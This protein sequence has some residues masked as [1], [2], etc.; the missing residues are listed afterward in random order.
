MQGTWL[1]VNKHGRIAVLTNYREKTSAQAVGLRSR[2]SIINSFLQLQPEDNVT[3]QQYIEELVA[4][5]DGHLA[6][7][8]SLACGDVKGPLAIVSNRVSAPDGITWIAEEKGQTVGLSNT[9][10]GDPSWKKINQ[11][12]EL[13]KSALHASSKLDESEDE[14]IARLL[15]LLSIDTL[16]RLHEG[17]DLETYINLLSESIYIPVIGDDREVKRDADEICGSKI[18][19]K[20]GVVSNG[21]TDHNSYMKGLYGTQK[22][23]VVLVHES[24]RVRFY[25]RTLYNDDAESIPI[26]EGDRSFEFTPET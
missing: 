12:E 13:M 26:G 10:F 2:G 22:Q 17:A 9:A 23:T 4:S 11:G 20:V 18:N 25:E 21:P 6:G 7:G 3:T 15:N 24:G 5:G 16:P 8:F 1:G 19:E 14:L